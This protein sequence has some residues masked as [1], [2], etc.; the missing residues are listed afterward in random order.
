MTEPTEQSG[1]KRLSPGKL[2]FLK[3]WQACRSFAT[4][5]MKHYAA[6]VAIRARSE[7]LGWEAVARI[8]GVR[9]LTLKRWVK[10]GSPKGQPPLTKAYDEK[11]RMRYYP[12][13]RLLSYKRVREPERSGYKTMRHL[14]QTFR[15]YDTPPPPPPMTETQARRW[16][17]SQSMSLREVARREGVT[18]ASVQASVRQVAR[19][20]ENGLDTKS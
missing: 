17:M 19:K 8:V 15:D 3:G 5:A 10:Q 12:N 9:S 18:L 13:P 7:G 4:K 16:Q 1:K 6:S 14:L 20:V 2:V 11:T